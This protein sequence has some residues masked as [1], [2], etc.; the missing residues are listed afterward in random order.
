MQMKPL[1]IHDIISM[2]IFSLY[3]VTDSTYVRTCLRTYADKTNLKTAAI[4]AVVICS[5]KSISVAPQHA[6]IWTNA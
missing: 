1:S 2:A 5:T 3:E 6:C 4:K